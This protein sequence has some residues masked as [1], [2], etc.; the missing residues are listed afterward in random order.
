[1]QKNTRHLNGRPMH[2]ISS[3]PAP[4]LCPPVHELLAMIVRFD[5][6]F[7]RHVSKVITIEDD[8]FKVLAK[9]VPTVI[10][11]SGKWQRRRQRRFR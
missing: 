6:T 3:Q 5:D 10:P 7:S 8:R 4:Y 9:M 1:M 2:H 11:H